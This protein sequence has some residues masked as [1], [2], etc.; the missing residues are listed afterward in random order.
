[1]CRRLFAA[2]PLFF[3]SATETSQPHMFTFAPTTASFVMTLKCVG[4]GVVQDDPSWP[5][6]S[7]RPSSL[8]N[9]AQNSRPIPAFP[10]FF[11]QPNASAKNI[12]PHEGKVGA[13]ARQACMDS[14]QAPMARDRVRTW[15]TCICPARH[16]LSPGDTAI[17]CTTTCFP[18]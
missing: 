18:G 16:V 2:N 4:W 10:L 17:I 9:L 3:S 5:R 6:S 11:S 14:H 7:R 15:C 13:R 1:M 12:P 8:S